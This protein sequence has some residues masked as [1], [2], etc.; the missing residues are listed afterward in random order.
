MS[1]VSDTEDNRDQ[2][3]RRSAEPEQC[4]PDRWRDSADA[5]SGVAR[6]SFSVEIIEPD[7]STQQTRSP[8]Q[9]VFIR[10]ICIPDFLICALFLRMLALDT[11][12]IHLEKVEKFGKM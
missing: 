12:H 9:V 5:T 2:P 11:L 8:S 1:S 6:L 7:S 10:L 4:F 3:S